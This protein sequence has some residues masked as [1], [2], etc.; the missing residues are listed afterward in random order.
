[1]VLLDT[2]SNDGVMLSLL[3][4][5]LVIC[6]AQF[7][8]YQ[9]RL[10]QVRKKM[11][12]DSRRLLG[13]QAEVS[14]L[15]KDRVQ[16]KFENQ[17]FEEFISQPNLDYAMKLLLTRYVPNEADGFGAWLEKQGNVFLWRQFRGLS[18]N[19][20]TTIPINEEWLTEFQQLDFQIIYED[21]LRHHFVFESLPAADRRRVKQLYVFPVRH[22][23][24]LTGFFMTTSLY[25][26][27]MAL[28]RKIS[29]ALRLLNGLESHFH[30]SQILRVQESQLKT[31]RE[32]L[33]LRDITDAHRNSVKDL[34]ELFLNCLTQQTRCA[35]SM[36]VFSRDPQF[37]EIRSI[38][39]AGVRPDDSQRERWERDEIRLLRIAAHRQS[40]IAL[41]SEE[42][43]L[44]GLGNPLKNVV[45]APLRPREGTYG[46]LCLFRHTSEQ[47]TEDDL[48]H[49]DW[50]SSYLGETLR[51]S[52]DT[53]TLEMQ[54]T[55]DPLTGLLNRRVFQEKLKHELEQ[56]KVKSGECSLL[57]LDL[58][59][60]K[61]VN[62]EF[63]HLAG[64]L[65]LKRVASTIL[66]T[67]NEA[68]EVN[69]SHTA[70]YGGEELA[71][72]LPDT[73]PEN[74]VAIAERIRE[75]VSAL[76]L[77][78]EGVK[79]SVTTS[80]GV[81]SFPAFGEDTDRLFQSADQALY[82]AKQSGRNRVCLAS[83]EKAPA[84]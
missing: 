8:L 38:Q 82:Q 58:D 62:D 22:Q 32:V 77:E 52:L 47:F 1:M 28:E 84:K 73:P 21:E 45:V 44:Y 48:R 39:R 33:E 49:I 75:A 16:S 19:E 46:M 53:A 9:H 66:R 26:T 13:L 74:A 67:L 76:D 78:F 25:P 14:T 83:S 72:I 30:H 18:T 60:F 5:V 40:H 7:V 4:T 43:E 64:D 37:R 51:R 68:E 54:A 56:A 80:V 59:H 63:G 69:R 65:V 61:A 81:A 71:A 31:T 70:R 11:A 20:L 79:C 17:I 23:K 50:A 35:R 6:I 57:L 3:L 15:Q 27:E 10:E 41:D 55:C 42:L 2:F 12:N 24:E 34:V 29:L 36:I